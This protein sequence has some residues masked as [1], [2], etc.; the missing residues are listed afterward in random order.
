MNRF[1]ILG[2]LLIGIG[3]SLVFSAGYYWGRQWHVYEVVH[4]HVNVEPSTMGSIQNYNIKS[5]G[6]TYAA[7]TVT[8]RKQMTFPK[9]QCWEAQAWKQVPC[10]EP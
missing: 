4:R 3:L 1:Q 9:N 7:I 5:Q 10:N 2:I 8:P 6:N